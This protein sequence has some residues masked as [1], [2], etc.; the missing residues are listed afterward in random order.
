[1]EESELSDLARCASCGDEIT[2]GIDRGFAASGDR[3]LCYDCAERRG[4][5]WDETRGIWTREPDLIGLP[6]PDPVER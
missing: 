2:P 3:V 6:H 4:G 1:M 5:V